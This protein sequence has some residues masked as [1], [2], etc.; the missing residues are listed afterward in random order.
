IYTL[1]QQEDG[2]IAIIVDIHPLE[3]DHNIIPISPLFTDGFTEIPGPIVED[4]F[5]VDSTGIYLRGYAPIYDQ[6]QT[7][8]G[9]LGI[10]ID[11][12]SVIANEN[13]FRRLSLFAFLISIPFSVLLGLRL[14]RFLSTPISDLMNGASR[15]EQGYLDEDVP[16]HSNDE[17]GILSRAFNNMASQLQ[18]TLGGLEMEIAAH[19]QSEKIQDVLFKIA[20]ATLSSERIED[21]SQIIH[22]LFCELIPA[23]NFYIALYDPTEEWISFPYYIDQYDEHP[24]AVKAGR[25]LTEY[26]LR[27]GKPLLATPDVLE[28]MLN[29]GEIELVGAMPIDWLGVPLIVGKRIIGVMAVQSYSEDVRFNQDVF[30][31]FQF[32][33]TQVS[34]AI[35]RKQASEELRLSNER[36][37]G[38]FEESPISLWEED[39]SAVKEI[40]DS[41][42]EDGVTDIESYLKSHPE[43]VK[44]CAEKV[45]ILDV[46]K[47]TMELFRAA[48]KEELLKNLAFIFKDDSF[49]V[50]QSELVNI[51]NGETNFSWEGVNQTL[52]GQE[53][54]IRLNWS[55]VPGYEQDLSKVIISLIDITESKKAEM[56]LKYLSHHDGLTNIYNRT[57]FDVEMSRLQQGR[58]F[59]IGIIVGDLDNLKDVNDRFGHAA[60]DEL[61]RRVA[62]AMRSSF[63]GDDVIARIGGDEF[64]V[65]LTNTDQK[66]TEKAMNRFLKN[67]QKLNSSQSGPLVQISLGMSSCEKTCSLTEALKK[68]DANM[69]QEKNTK[70]NKR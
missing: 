51:A 22:S 36:Y 7:L 53:L 33:S 42:V 19:K 38:L 50:F 2:Q 61:I 1:R 48:T 12:A 69:Y 40:L 9:V 32:I 11:A 35:D 55:V 3:T 28:N 10:E 4:E 31:L 68:A 41:L 66:L 29:E 20:Q 44:E 65:L 58:Q 64:A 13:R 54:D 46:N 25:G 16:I 59:P 21:L 14:S 56:K 26:I 45:K 17:L 43:L 18:K 39:F 8:D 62:Q 27:T 63:R 49:Q 24:P 60:G 5:H 6:F 37:Y 52:D 57:Y 34:F 15:I 47:A 70:Q 30:D 67:I 23:E